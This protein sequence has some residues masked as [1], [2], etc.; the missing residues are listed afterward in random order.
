MG[1]ESIAR[2]VYS[3]VFASESQPPGPV[4]ILRRLIGSDRIRF[5]D[6]RSTIS[7]DASGFRVAIE[8]GLPPETTCFRFA[9]AIAVVSLVDCRPRPIDLH[10][11][12]RLALAIVMPRKALRRALAARGPRLDEIGRVFVISR[13]LVS[14]RLQSVGFALASGQ[15]RTIALRDAG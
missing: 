9:T 8:R 2:G 13:E 5:V 4:V 12:R 3:Q 7:R 10:E 11:V 15:Y 14:E 1:L 6:G